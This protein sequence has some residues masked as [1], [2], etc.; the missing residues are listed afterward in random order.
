MTLKLFLGGGEGGGNF[1]LP[2]FSSSCRPSDSRILCA[3]GTCYE[4]LGQNT[5]AKKVPRA[6]A[7]FPVL[8]PPCFSL[9]ISSPAYS[10]VL[11]LSI[12]SPVLS[13]SFSSLL[14]LLLSS[15]PVSEESAG[16]QGPG[17]Y[18]SC[19]AGKV[20]ERGR[21]REGGEGGC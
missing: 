4:E 10:P 17:G 3:L 20:R 11:G 1:F 13:L 14:S 19:E 15:H 18:R 12:S 16:I 21:E 5:E 8:L 7:R 9:S 6:H 2:H